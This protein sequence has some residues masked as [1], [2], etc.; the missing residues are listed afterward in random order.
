MVKKRNINGGSELEFVIKSYDTKITLKT[1]MI[2]TILM[3]KGA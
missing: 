1:L 3:I 2:L